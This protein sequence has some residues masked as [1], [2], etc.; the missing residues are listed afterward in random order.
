VWDLILLNVHLPFLVEGDL[1][2]Q[3]GAVTIGERSL[4]AL[5]A[6]YARVTLDAAIDAIFDS[7]ERQMREAIRTVPNGVYRAERYLD[8]DGINK[9]RR[10]AIRVAVR[11][12]DGEMTFD[13]TDSDPQAQGY[14]N[15]TVPNTAS[16]AFIA[17]F[18]S[19]GS[20]VRFNEGALRA[21]HEIA[22]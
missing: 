21:L 6:K 7:S 3:V 15:S 1:N 13:F 17:L 16:S 18:L 19:I 4:K 20:E 2:C 10:L 8:H 14:V 9:D 22:T 11:V 12:K 5:L